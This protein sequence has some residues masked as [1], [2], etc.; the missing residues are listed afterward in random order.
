MSEPVAAEFNDVIHSPVRLRICALMRRTS[1]LEF[2][3]IRDTLGLNDANL[4][5]NLKVL[6]E[7]RLVTVRK[8]SS[9]ART[10]ARRLTWVALTAEGRSA[11]EGH[12][13]ALTQIADSQP[14]VLP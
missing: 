9:A 2:A 6:S 12:L 13:A 14:D 4:S 1:E 11:L 7:G 3:V 8:E 10:D 5:K